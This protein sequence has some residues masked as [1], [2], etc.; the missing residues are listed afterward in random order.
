MFNF[1]MFKNNPP[2]DQLLTLLENTLINMEIEL[3]NSPLP[4]TTVNNVLK[5]ID[6]ANAY[7][8]DLR[9]THG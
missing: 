2:K 5:F 3:Y 7:I 8:K 1:G 6:E 4:L 9:K